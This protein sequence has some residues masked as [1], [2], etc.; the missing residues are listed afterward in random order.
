MQDRNLV[1]KIIKNNN[2]NQKKKIDK[3]LLKFHP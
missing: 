3:W 2:Q 1:L